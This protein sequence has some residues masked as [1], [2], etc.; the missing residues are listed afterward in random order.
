MTFRLFSVSV[1][2]A[3]AA[4]AQVLDIGSRRELFVDRY[5]IDRMTG[6]QLRLGQP[7]DTGAVLHFDKPWEGSFCGYVT[8]IK[9]GGRYRMYYRGIPEAGQDGNNGE[10]TCYA[11]SAD[12]IRWTKPDL[13][14]YEIRGTRQNNVILANDAPFSHNFSP[15]L[16]TRPGVPAEERFKALAGVSQTGLVAFVSGDGVHWRKLRSEAV[17]PKLDAFAFDSQ[18]QAFWSE[19]EQQYVCYFRTWKKVDGVNYRWISRTT[20]R[21]FLT[22]TKPVEMNFGDAPAEHIYTNQTSPYYRAPHLGIGLCARF[23]P[24]RQVLTAEQAR[25]VGVDPGYFKDCSDAV[26]ISTRGGDRYDRTFLEAFIRP[27]LGLENWVSRSNYPALN[28]IPTSEREMSLYVQSNYGQPTA[29]LR[30]YKLRPDGFAS[31]NA[32]YQGGEWVTKPLRFAGKHLTLNYSTS[33]PGSVRVEIQDEGGQ[34]LP[35]YSLADAQ[36]LIGDEL[37]RVV[38]WKNGSDVGALAGRTVK[39]RFVMKDADHYAIRF[40]E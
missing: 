29:Y 7:V 4:T 40:A 24:G 6:T 35:G 23:L 39:L 3:A 26:L 10:V 20:S 17:I 11:E 38:A 18:N 30:R 36:E 15:L 2:L 37:D 28:V 12:G 19:T 14:I 33:A 9:D 13:G 21:D 5:L 16:D 1:L 32:G 34:P 22:W 31:I 8:V 27:G 25:A